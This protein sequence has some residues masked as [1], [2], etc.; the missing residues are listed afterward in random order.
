MSKTSNFTIVPI[1]LFSHITD[2]QIQESFTWKPV[3]LCKVTYCKNRL[4]TITLSS[5]QSSGEKVICSCACQSCIISFTSSDLKWRPRRASFMGQKW[6][7][8]PDAKAHE[9]GRWGD[10]F[11][12]KSRICYMVWY[13]VWGW[14]LLCC[15]QTPADKNKPKAFSW[16][17]CLKLIQK[18]ITEQ[19]SS[20]HLNDPCNTQGTIIFVPYMMTFTLK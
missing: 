9:Y 2:P 14:A 18:H 13:T 6:W 8:L 15:R 16:N 7:K 20:F 12:F 1:P 5:V 4:S 10:T 17:C 11:N 3:K 19:F